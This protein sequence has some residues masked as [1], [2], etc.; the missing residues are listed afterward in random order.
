MTEEPEQKQTFEIQ[1]LK[2]EIKELQKKWYSRPTT[3]FP[4]LT[5]II[6]LATI[7]WSFSSGLLNVQLQSLSL[8]KETLEFD[9]KKFNDDKERLFSENKNL[10]DN[11]Q[12]TKN[13]FKQTQSAFVDNYNKREKRIIDSLNK[14]GK[15]NEIVKYYKQQLDSI[16]NAISQQKAS[17]SAL[18]TESGGY[19]LTEDGGKILL[20]K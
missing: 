19:L 18:K 7:I 13:K 5:F 12:A 10:K 20:E 8:K 9:I 15:C 16:V 3:L 14:T 6:A 17:T 2:L 11:L 4:V 1:K